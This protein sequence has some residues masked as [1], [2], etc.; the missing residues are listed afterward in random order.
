MIVLIDNYDS[1]TYNIYQ[2]LACLGETIQV[3]RS[4]E[5]SPSAIEALAPNHLIISPGPGRPEDAGKSLELINL[6]KGKIPILGICLG[7]QCIG[8]LFGGKI[9][10]AKQICHGKV[11]KIMH[12][13]LGV[14]QGLPSPLMETRYH[15]LVIEQATCPSELIVTAQSLDGE[16]MGVKHRD[17]SLE[18]VQ[19]HPE[20]IASEKGMEILKNFVNY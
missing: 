6:F 20:S 1:F 2:Y 9:V 19:F 11:D 7:H 17:Y 3:F 14:F 5:I 13:G 15:S 4:K 12:S 8:Q 16:I 18:G 10:R